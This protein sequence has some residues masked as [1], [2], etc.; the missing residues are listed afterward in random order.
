MPW[1]FAGRKEYAVACWV[2]IQR[3]PS[4][5]EQAVLW[6]ITTQQGVGIGMYLR[7][8]PDGS[9]A[10]LVVN[11]NVGEAG[12]S[13][14]DADR[15]LSDLRLQPRTWY[16]VAVRHA[17]PKDSF[18]S[19]F[20]KSQLNVFVDGKARLEATMP[21]PSPPTAARVSLALGRNLNGQMG[22]IFVFKEAV[23][24]ETLVLLMKQV[25]RGA[26]PPNMQ[27]PSPDSTLYNQRRSP[28]PFTWHSISYVLHLL[29]VGQR[30]QVG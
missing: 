12:T 24:P 16:H 8:T 28:P 26:T 22:A 14:K 5:G 20:S 17:P 30:T 9:G 6:Q 4:P 18:F 11:A 27:H 1:P 10:T 3:L 15:V 21:V 7:S 13:K 25:S 2:R 29:L 19:Y 23:S